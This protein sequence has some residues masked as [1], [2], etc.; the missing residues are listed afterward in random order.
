VTPSGIVVID[1][2][3]GVTSHDVVARVRRILGTRRVGHAGTLDPM[4]TGVLVI[5][6]ERATRLLGHIAATD[7]DYRA[8][9][10]LG[11]ATRSDDAEGEVI[12]RADPDLIASTTETLI[13]EAAAT[14]T[15]TI[16]QRPSA[17]SAIKVDGRRAHERV[18][19]GEV[20]DL[21]GRL[22]RVDR[23]DVLTV[24]RS[25]HAIDLEVEVTCGSGTYVRAL[26]RDLGA[27]LGIG[28]HLTALRRTRV[29]TFDAPISLADLESRGSAAV[30]PMGEALL[31][32]FPRWIVT[33]EEG[34]LIGRGQRLAWT[35]P[36]TD[37]TVAV[38]AGD[39]SLLA[40]AHRDA[41]SIRYL[42]VF[43]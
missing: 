19:A 10:R 38:V 28:G 31:G 13:R 27:R 9:V 35:G 12:S 25:P 24:D 3:G 11:S 43:A 29:G 7:K 21:P 37:G 32:I 18:R 8:T 41:G 36:D 6:V 15:G 30:Q 1:K 4:A 5:G 20:V 17:V 22:V 33:A 26:A 16:E 14:L 2:P 23:L 39:G 42:A 34:V 40:L